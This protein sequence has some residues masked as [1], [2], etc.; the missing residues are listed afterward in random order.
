MIQRGMSNEYQ[1]HLKCQGLKRAKTL[2]EVTTS[3]ETQT[4]TSVKGGHLGV[5]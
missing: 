5:S 2:L 4:V 3:E 1:N